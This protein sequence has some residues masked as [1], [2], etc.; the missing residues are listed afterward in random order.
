[1]KVHAFSGHWGREVQLGP[2][3]VMFAHKWLNYHGYHRFRVFY[4]PYWRR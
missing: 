3:V 4:D 1:M 2:F